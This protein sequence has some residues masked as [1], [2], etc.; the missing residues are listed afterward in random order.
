MT[1]TGF[2]KGMSIGVVTGAAV[3]MVLAPRGRNSKKTAGKALRAAGEVLD[4]IT[5]LWS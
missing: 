4:N 1:N 3:G 5:G 2:I